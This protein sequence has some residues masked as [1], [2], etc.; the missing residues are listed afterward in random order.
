MFGSDSNIDQLTLLELTLVALG[1]R[2]YAFYDLLLLDH[3]HNNLKF[4]VSHAISL[5]EN[6][7]AFML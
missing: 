3:S 2:L 4:L 6:L 1:S 7:R 5:V